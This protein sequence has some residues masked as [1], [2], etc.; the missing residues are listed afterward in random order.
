VQNS[1]GIPLA[2]FVGAIVLAGAT[3]FSVMAG[4]GADPALNELQI[5]AAAWAVTLAMFGA[6][7]IVSIVLEGRQLRVGTIGPRLTSPLSVAIA[8]CSILL[9]VL[10]G[11]TGL[12]IVAGQPTAVVGTAAGAGYWTTLFQAKVNQSA[13][14]TL[15][16]RFPGHSGAGGCEVVLH[17]PHGGLRPGRQ[18]E[19]GEE[20]RHVTV[21]CSSADDQLFCDLPIRVA[22]R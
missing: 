4:V 5:G 13:S 19:L 21:R 3:I 14:Q 1:P 2:A 17:R 6:Q 18:A 8:A 9:L 22:A 10:A 20:M 11:L 7:G 16:T 12:A 15:I